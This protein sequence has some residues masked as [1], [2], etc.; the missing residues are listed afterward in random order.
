MYYVGAIEI[1]SRRWST[2]DANASGEPLSTDGPP[3]V[4]ER[5]NPLPISYRP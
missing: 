5:A 1:P 4:H 3:S 2:Y